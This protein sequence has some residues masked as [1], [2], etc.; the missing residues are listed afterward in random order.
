MKR[1]TY[2]E[3]AD[4]PILPNT[5]MQLLYLAQ[6]VVNKSSEFGPVTPMKLQKL[7]YYVKAWGLVADH[8]LVPADFEKWDYGP[9]NPWIYQRF[10]QYSRDPIPYMDVPPQYAPTS[11]SKELA[12]FITVCYSQFNALTLSAMTHKEAP[13]KNTAKNQVIPEDLMHS[14]YSQRKFAE[15]FPFD[16]DKGPFY[17][18]ESDLSHAFSM[19]MTQEDAERA[20]TFESYRSYLHHLQ[21]ASGEF[22]DKFNRLLQ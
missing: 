11:H 17:T 14:Y 5:T 8:E 18:V 2:C 4:L 15:N 9:V 3:P 6:Y 19:D 7:L 13:W 10:K 20:R 12:D 1:L 21:K 16:P 22:H